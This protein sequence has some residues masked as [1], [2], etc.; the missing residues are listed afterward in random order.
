MKLKILQKINAIQVKS[1]AVHLAKFEKKNHSVSQVLTPRLWN[2]SV[3]ANHLVSI[4]QIPV[5][6]LSMADEPQIHRFTLP[7]KNA[8]GLS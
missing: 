6:K 4:M 8:Y 1:S 7:N 3:F 5:F 2:Y